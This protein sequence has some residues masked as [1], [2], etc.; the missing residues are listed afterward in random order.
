MQVECNGLQK[1][2]SV[3]RSEKQDMVNKH[4]KEK[5]SLQNE[6]ASLRAEKE[7]L[8]KCSLK[9]KTNLQS[10]CA[11]LHSEKEAV[12]H[13]QQQLEKDLARSVS[14]ITTNSAAPSTFVS[15]L[16]NFAPLLYSIPNTLLFVILH[17]LNSV[18]FC[19][20]QFPCSEC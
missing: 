3:L 13:K 16:L 10:D 1:E 2:C 5:I 11:V 8:S 15:H 7:E 12:L 14:S 19:F 4:Q 17:L 9:E 20:S 6:C 18:L